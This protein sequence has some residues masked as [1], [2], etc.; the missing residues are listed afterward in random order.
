MKGRVNLATLK[1]RYTGRSDIQTPS[2]G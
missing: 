1:E 2:L